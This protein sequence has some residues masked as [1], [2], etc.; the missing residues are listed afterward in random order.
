MKIS[1]YMTIYLNYWDGCNKKICVIELWFY[2][3]PII[4]M[5]KC[6]W[7]FKNRLLI[8]YKPYSTQLGVNFIVEK[9]YIDS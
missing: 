1:S 4:A 3:N 5:P 6:I 9:D 7:L 8:R 2:P